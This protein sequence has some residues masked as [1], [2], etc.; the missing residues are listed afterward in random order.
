MTNALPVMALGWA[1]LVKDISNVKFDGFADDEF[2]GDV[3]H[4]I[5][6]IT[7]AIDHRLNVFDCIDCSLNFRSLRAL[8][9]ASFGRSID[10]DNALQIILKLC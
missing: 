9:G 8:P 3:V 7:R 4:P 2:M 6:M 1:L 5:I 10:A